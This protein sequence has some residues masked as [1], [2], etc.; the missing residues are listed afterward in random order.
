MKQNVKNIIRLAAVVL[1]LTL[2]VSGFSCGKAQPEQ[3][4]TQITTAVTET[5]TS[6]ETTAAAAESTALT[7]TETSTETAEPKEIFRAVDTSAFRGLYCLDYTADYAFDGFLSSGGASDSLQLV[8]YG[9]S[10]FP[11]MKL[12]LSNLGYGCSAFYAASDDSRCVFGRNFD[13]DAKNSGSYLVVHTNPDGAYESFSTVN[14]KFI[15]IN[16][17]PE[18]PGDETSPLLFS[19]YVPLDGINEKGVSIGVLQLDFAEISQNDAEKID[20]TS[21][22]I[23]RYVLDYAA[24]TDEAIKIFEECNLHTEGFAYHY[25]IG[26]ANGNGAVIEYVN[27]KLVTKRF[28]T[29][30]GGALVCANSFVT[31]EGVKTYGKASADSSKRMAAI[32][33]ALEKCGFDI[34]VENALHALYSGSQTTTR[35]S[36][37]FDC[38]NRTMDIA[39]NRNTSKF[40]KFSFEE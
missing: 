21:T 38:T 34:S 4:T 1:A 14:L 25:M 15:G 13:M 24:S 20:M 6:R 19:P 3:Q 18:A 5:T 11:S 10:V 39:V 33:S 2:C 23:I 37:V 26:D 36:V 30:D 7:E 32:V 35:W 29:S 9:M 28:N 22:S 31:D 8:Q 16:G 17:A 40:Y 27:G 12:S